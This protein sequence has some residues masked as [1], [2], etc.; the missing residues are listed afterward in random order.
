MYCTLLKPDQKLKPYLK[1][2]SQ[3]EGGK[4]ENGLGTE[5]HQ[6]ASVAEKFSTM[7][8]GGGTTLL[9]QRERVL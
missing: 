2:F 4:E 8:K 7:D 3:C 9:H 5:G 6:Y 1:V